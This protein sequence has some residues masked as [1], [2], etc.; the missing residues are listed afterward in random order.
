MITQ[1]LYQE[2]AKTTMAK[3]IETI[4]NIVS[5]TLGP[6][7]C[8]TILYKNSNIPQILNNGCTITKEI[9]LE[10][11]FENTGV[12]LIRQAASKTYEVVGDGTTRTIL[13]AYSLIHYGMNYV[14]VGINTVDLIMGM[15]KAIEFLSDKIIEYAQPVKDTQTLRQIATVASGNDHKIGATIAK[16]IEEIGTEGFISLEESTTTNTTIEITKGIKLDKGLI[17]SSFIKGGKTRIIQDDP[18]I[19]ITD[20][21]ITLVQEELIPVLELVG[22]TDRPLLILAEDFSTEVLST[23]A[24]NYV[25][26]I[27]NVAAIRIPGFGTQRK[28]TLEDICF[29]T[30]GKIISEEVG[31]KLD[32]I[33]LS[34]LGEANKIFIDNNDTTIIL[35]D[36]ELQIN[37]RCNQLRKQINIS[38]TIYERENL[39]NRLARISGK[40]ATIKIGAST[41]SELQARKASF[42]EGLGSVHAAV[43]EG[44]IP[45]GESISIHL[46]FELLAWAKESLSEDELKGALLIKKSL[47]TPLQIIIQ[48]AG[49]NHSVILEKLKNSN[50]TIGYNA[51][52]GQFVNM[53]KEGIIDSAKIMR[54][55]LQNAVSIAKMFLT[56]ECI[57][58][59]NTKNSYI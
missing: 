37:E 34:M 30:N 43:E 35:K 16:V 8:N 59:N 2:Q 10:N 47:V 31:I 21:K 48:N 18:Y 52:E 58:V 29:I 33:K 39:Q 22:K 44:I 45:G 38:N 53:Y 26:G 49:Y 24:I 19:L 4:A 17:S 9:E 7:G 36:K 46:A 12:K 57:I 23:L 55:I 1:I 32:S 5:V 50:L 27:M 25:K 42:R 3:G 6:S 20:K 11:P 40:T 13:I 51:E 28:L 15:E 14:N 56:T 41:S 54:L